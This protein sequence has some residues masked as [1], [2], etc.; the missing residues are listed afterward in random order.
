M[1]EVTVC[2]NVEPAHQV[3]ENVSLRAGHFSK[4]KLPNLPFDKNLSSGF[5][6]ED[7]VIDGCDKVVVG[8]IVM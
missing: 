6:F 1:A 5:C 4:R 3:G 2:K 8:F 7:I